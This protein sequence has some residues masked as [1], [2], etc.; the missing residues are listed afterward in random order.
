[1]S[2]QSVDGLLKLAGEVGLD[3]MPDFGAFFWDSNGLHGLTR[4]R[5][6]VI[7]TDSGE[8]ALEGNGT[9]TWNEASLGGER[10]LRID[11]EPVDDDE[12]L[13]LPMVVGAASVSAVYLT[14]DPE[15]LVRFPSYEQL[16]V[17]PKMPVL[18]V[19]PRQRVAPAAVEAAPFVA[20][21]AE[22]ADVEAPEAPEAEAEQAPEPDVEAEQPVDPPVEQE[23][24][25]EPERAAEPELAAEEQPEGGFD[26]D[27]P[28]DTDALSDPS[29]LAAIDEPAEP[30][31]PAAEQ[32]SPVEPR[33]EDAPEFPGLGDE[34]GMN[35]STDPGGLIAAP[36][37]PE[38]PGVPPVAPRCRS[39]RRS[40][41]RRPR[42]PAPRAR[43][44]SPDPRGGRRRRGRHHLL[45]GPRR[46]PQAC[47]AERAASGSAGARRPVHQRPR[48]RARLPCV[49]H[50]PGAGRLVQSAPDPSTPARGRP[51]QPRRL[52]RRHRRRRDRPRP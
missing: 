21:A 17:L 5:V 48:Q 33:H 46:D 11:L 1:M 43:C 32:E 40:V 28:T 22:V 2:A 15:A 45:D 12:V 49:P 30:A 10:H 42:A 52:R 23:P 27:H 31:E 7:D 13:Q 41:P 44:G 14:T 24:I 20:D 19:R 18:G 8:V 26:L 9:V 3:A 51:H 34:V 47:P 35:D 6:R 16:G 39:R 29:L 36:I 38:V 37:A 25:V 50:L 4:G